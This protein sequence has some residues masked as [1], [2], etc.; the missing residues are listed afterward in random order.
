MVPSGG[1]KRRSRKG[2]RAVKLGDQRPVELADRADQRASDQ[3]VLDAVGV[4]GV[5][6]PRRRGLVEL[7]AEHLGGEPD[8][9]VY[10]VP[11]HHSIEIPLEF[12]LLGEILRPVVGGLKAVAVEVV[13]NV[14]ARPGIC[15]LIPRTAHAGVLLDDR[16]R[17][18]RLLQANCSEQTG[19]A[20]THDDDGKPGAVLRTRLEGGDPLVVALEF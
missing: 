11:A 5:Y 12:G 4:T 2:F 16:V 7:R 13:S 17:N 15:V 18:S 6:R 9:L 14:D 19:L 10:T 3:N 8:V 1:V 20:T